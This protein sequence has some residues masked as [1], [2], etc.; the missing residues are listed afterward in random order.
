MYFD[1]KIFAAAVVS[2]AVKGFI[3]IEHLEDGDFRLHRLTNDKSLLSLGERKVADELFRLGWDEITLKQAN[4]HLI[5]PAMEALKKS[6]AAEYET[7]YFRR[8]A[9]W[10]VVGLGIALVTFVAVA[11]QVQFPGF[12]LIVGLGILFYFVAGLLI[13]GFDYL[14]MGILPKTAMFFGAFIGFGFLLFF[15]MAGFDLRG[16]SLLTIVLLACL[17][18]AHALFQIYIKA[19]T[20]DGRRVMDE[21]EGLKLYMS[22]AEKDRLNLLNPP[23]RTPEHFERLLPYALALDVENAWAERFADVLTDAAKADA[24]YSPGWYDGSSWRSFSA[25]SFSAA[26]GGGL[27]AAVSSASAAPGSSSGGGGGGFSG[28]GGGGGGGGGW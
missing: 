20:A 15:M 13:G 22:V 23:A 3:R 14:R 4:H 25:G 27:A 8:N 17:A 6:L 7:A 24:G 21:I 1:D 5:G 10:H 18:V 2:M 26:L 19:P 16:V 9:V 28:G 11:I 12:F